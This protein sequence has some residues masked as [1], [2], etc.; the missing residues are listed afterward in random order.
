MWK[1]ESHGLFD[2][3]SRN[4]LKSET[5]FHLNEPVQLIVDPSKEKVYFSALQFEKFLDKDI[6]KLYI[7]MKTQSIMFK[8]GTVSPNISSKMWKYL[9]PS[10]SHPI[11]VGETLRMGKLTLKVKAI[12]ILD[13]DGNNS[14]GKYTYMAE[15]GAHDKVI[16]CNYDESSE[17]RVCMDKQQP[18]NPFLV[19]C[20]CSKAMPTHIN[21]VRRWLK[22]KCEIS[23]STNTVFYDLKNIKCEVCNASYP[24]T[25]CMNNKTYSLFSTDVESD[26][27]YAIFELF[28]KNSNEIKGLNVL[29]LKQDNMKFTVGRSNDNDVIFNDV[30]VSRVHAE[31]AFNNN[32]LMVRDLNSKFGTHVL[33]NSISLS[34]LN[35]EIHLQMEKFYLVFHVTRGKKCFC[36]SKNPYSY[37]LNPRDP[38]ERLKKEFCKQIT[39]SQQRLYNNPEDVEEVGIE[40]DQINVPSSMEPPI[41]H[42]MYISEDR[43]QTNPANREDSIRLLRSL[44]DENLEG[45]RRVA[46]NELQPQTLIHVPIAPENIK[47]DVS[48]DRPN[49]RPLVNNNYSFNIQN[50]SNQ[51]IAEVKQGLN[52]EKGR[53]TNLQIFNDRPDFRNMKTANYATYNTGKGNK[54]V[55]NNRDF[56]EDNEEDMFGDPNEI[57]FSEIDSNDDFRFN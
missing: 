33:I 26:Q 10:S 5:N 1:K 20:K 22:A 41:T 15:S 6:N 46:N 13:S 44:I 54:K 55:F 23:S 53:Q 31:I 12:N 35:K 21:C 24:L 51:Q 40:G 32:R 43:L 19:I 42:N 36:V 16:D 9:V 38:L 18:D 8:P 2:F 29:F 52:R 28:E 37:V 34:A 27:S 17:C 25:V 30:S 4:H 50:M 49:E 11:S 45:N 39:S 47:N 3:T 56:F 14:H 48:K 57:D 7:D